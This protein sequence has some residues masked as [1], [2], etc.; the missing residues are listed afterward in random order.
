MITNSDLTIY[1]KYI[2]INTEKVEYIKTYIYGVNFQVENLVAVTDKGLNGANIATFFIPMNSDFSG[3]S[4]KKPIQFNRSLDKSD[5]F[6]LK[7]G[8]IVVK[9]ICSFEFSDGKPSE[10]NVLKNNYDDVYSIISVETNEYGSEHMKHWK[11]GA[12]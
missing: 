8:D 10:I 11:I 2:N 1:N 7:E 4:Y 9:G 3:K 6:T 5:I 12:K